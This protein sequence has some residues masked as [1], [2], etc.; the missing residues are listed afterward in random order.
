[1]F[2]KESENVESD[3]D[4]VIFSANSYSQ[5]TSFI[6]KQQLYENIHNFYT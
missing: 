2:W 5:G 3:I 1:M 6:N 4:S